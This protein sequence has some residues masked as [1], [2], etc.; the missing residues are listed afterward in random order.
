ME[1]KTKDITTYI[2]VN[3]ILLVVALLVIFAIVIEYKTNKKDIVSTINEGTNVI[4][5]SIQVEKSTQK[6]TTENQVVLP[7]IVDSN[8]IVSDAT[9]SSSYY[10]YYY[11]QL[12]NNSKKIYNTIEDNIDNIKS[13]DYTINL[14]D[15][16]AQDANIKSGTTIINREFQSAWDAIILDRE[17]L[18]Y[19][20][21]SKICLRIRTTTLGNTV[22][23]SLYMTPNSNTYLENGFTNKQVVDMALS[24]VD[25]VSNQI[26]SNLSG[27]NYEKIVQVNDWL[28]DNVEYDTS[29]QENSYNLYGALV[30]KKA[31]CEGYAESF[32]YI[33]DKIGI[34]CVT[35]MGT[36]QNSEG[37]TENHEWNYVELDGK[38][39]AVDATWDDPILEGYAKLTNNIKHKYICK[40]SR[41]MNENHFPNGKISTD[42]ITFTYPNLEENNY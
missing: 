18:F 32:K 7:I 11:N 3:L 24:N 4:I 20:D 1:R 21:V 12:D 40:G 34:P 5:S 41:T 9:N 30:E 42:G 15:S 26:I 22:T 38:W 23:Y 33:M 19:I 17:D 31:V 36:A 16:I 25:A 10:K 6:E 13:G 28:V 2:L 39:Y 35:V 14:S 37:T 8:N 27:S 29:E